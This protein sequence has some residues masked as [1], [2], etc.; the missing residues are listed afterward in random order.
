MTGQT[1]TAHPNVDP[2]TGNMVAIGY[3]ASG[4]CTDAMRMLFDAGTSQ[5][6]MSPPNSKLSGTVIVQ[7]SADRL[8]W[9]STL[10]DPGQ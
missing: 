6:P 2:K 10:Q 7:R 3:A 8:P 4:L 1:F 5:M 9:P